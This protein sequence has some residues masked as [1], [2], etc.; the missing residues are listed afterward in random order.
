MHKKI[1]ILT[2]SEQ[3]NLMDKSIEEIEEIMD[4]NLIID[5][6]EKIEET[7]D[8]FSNKTDDKNKQFRFNA[9]RGMFTYPDF[10]N[11]DKYIE[12]FKKEFETERREVK[13]IRLAHEIGETG[14]KHTH[15]LF[16]MDINL[17]IRKVTRFDY[18]LNF[19]VHLV[20]KY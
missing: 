11:K 6:D 12:W 18:P 20:L 5:N 15:V 7:L 10:I 1:N 13:F 3:K 4:E 17:D 19:F 9:A 2:L 14:H 16:K 8:S